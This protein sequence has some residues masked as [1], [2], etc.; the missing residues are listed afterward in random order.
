[1]SAPAALTS[2]S[3][4]PMDTS[5]TQNPPNGPPKPIYRPRRNADPLRRRPDPKARRERL[6]GSSGA[7]GPSHH[8]TAPIN[9]LS[10]PVPPPPQEDASTWTTF[11][12]KTTKRELMK[13]LRYH[14]MRLQHKNRVDITE[15]D[16]FTLPIRLHRRDPRAPPQG[17]KEEQAALAAEE[18]G[19]KL[20]PEEQKKLEEAQAAKEA[21]QAATLAA[22]A[23]YGGAQRQKKNAFKKKTQQV[24]QTDEA[25]KK[26]R[27]EEYFP[28]HIEDFD[29]KNTWV[30]NLEGALSDGCQAIFVMDG[31]CF[32]MIPVEKWY[33]FTQRSNFKTLSI[34]E[35]EAVMKKKSKTPRWLME[36]TK[37]DEKA[38]KAKEEAENRAAMKS[39]YLVKGDR[40]ANRPKEEVADADELDFEDNFQDD[41]EAPIME[42]EEEENRQIEKRI[43]KE[44]L[45]ANLFDLKDEKEYEQEE[46]EKKRRAQLE[47]K[48]GKKV[49][50]YLRG[51]EKNLTYESDSDENPYA[52]TSEDSSAEEAKREEER[53]KAEEKKREEERKQL[54]AEKKK[55]EEEEAKK[56]AE[57][58][59]AEKAAS[60]SSLQVKGADADKL[61]KSPKRDQKH[62][63]LKRTTA[64]DPYA[65]ESGTDTG[66][67]RKKPRKNA[68]VSSSSSSVPTGSPLASSSNTT[69]GA[70]SFSSPSKSASPPLPPG[71]GQPLPPKKIIRLKLGPGNLAQVAASSTTNAT[72]KRPREGGAGS[73]NEA[74]AAEV[75]G[76]E[77]LAKKAK[78][79]IKVQQPCSGPQSGGGAAAAAPRPAGNVGTPRAATP[80]VSGS[81]A[82]SP[83]TGGTPAPSGGSA[84]DITAD[85]I[86]AVLKLKPE[87]QEL[88]EFL[89]HFKGRVDRNTMA[90]FLALLKPL[91]RQK[92]K[93][94]CPK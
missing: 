69:T 14:V 33:K 6:T 66:S 36:V 34:E 23:P 55:R 18:E 42:G 62:K 61:T 4:T 58:T 74:A 7:A 78:I 71:T 5:T 48:T 80:S 83:G 90:P 72:K 64:A 12:L 82:A 77:T 63:Q 24:Y 86:R 15:P 59:A 13:G 19:K 28:W 29:N 73:D 46:R 53:K 47:K 35:A 60:A 52:S 89:S 32:R 84:I 56:V 1:M 93:L 91:S 79:K 68:P 25:A 26:L 88:K 40:L 67:G 70:T 16:Q 44:Q 49:I 30:G 43:K 17:A 75:S 9:H 39:M 37:M 20:D 85:E 10:A 38:Q 54:E 45:G 41:E 22:I 11:K 94:I 31:N 87:G 2:T 8:K 21:E 92:G 81:R 51:H 57:K 3:S 65:S 50:K 27:Y 76:G